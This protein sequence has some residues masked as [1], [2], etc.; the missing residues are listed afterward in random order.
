MADEISLANFVRF[1][2]KGS[3][4]RARIGPRDQGLSALG[5]TP[6][7]A[8]AFLMMP[9]EGLHSPFDDEWRD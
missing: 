2:R 9:C 4:W 5:T 1:Q 6:F 7:H 8:V 3:R